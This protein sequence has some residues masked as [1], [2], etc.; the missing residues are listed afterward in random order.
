[1]IF[2]PPIINDGGQI[3]LL[4]TTLKN[5]K[6]NRVRFFFLPFPAQSQIVC[7][8]KNWNGIS[9]YIRISI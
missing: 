4:A 5:A 7:H 2:L 1:M 9:I 8:N 3:W 6:T